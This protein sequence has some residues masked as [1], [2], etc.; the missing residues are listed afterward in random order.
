[1]LVVFG[2]VLVFAIGIVVRVYWIPTHT[3]SHPE[4]YVPGI[5]MP[6]G[7]SQP[8]ERLTVMKVLSGNY[9]SD[10]HPPGFFLVM[11]LWTKVFGTGIWSLRLQPVLLG[12]GTIA[13]LVWLGKLL[14]QT[15]A[16][17]LAAA[18]LAVNGF[19]VFWSQ[20]SRMF[21]QSCFLG[22][23]S[24]ILLLQL[25]RK[26]ETDRL[27]MAAYALVTLSGLATHIFYW[28]LF[29][30][31][32]LWAYWNALRTVDRMSAVCGLQL[33]ILLLGSP[34][35]AAAAYQSQNADLAYLSSNSWTMGREY[36]SF[37]FLL[38]LDGHGGTA[39]RLSYPLE[40]SPLQVTLF[41]IGR[42]AAFL[43]A[44]VCLIA[45]IPSR[46]QA[47][48]ICLGAPNELGYKTWLA[49]AI[50]AAAVI[51]V[52]VSFA[53]A[54]AHPPNNSLRITEAMVVLPLL[55]AAAGS[56]MNLR[57]TLLAAW[58]RKLRSG[59]WLGGSLALVYVQAFVPFALLSIFSLARPVLNARGLLVLTP[60]LLLCLAVGMVVLA[61]GK[62]L[63]HALLVFVLG[64]L[65]IT[66]LVSYQP[67]SES[68]VDFRMLSQK[69]IA[70]VQPSDIILIRR[71]WSD[72]PIL[73]YL[74]AERFHLEEI[75]QTSEV[76][77]RPSTNRVWVLNYYSEPLKRPVQPTLGDFT[78]ETVL[79]VYN[80]RAVLYSR[81]K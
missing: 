18:L 48:E 29:V 13:L 54:F 50:F 6:D 55:M 67:R 5:R 35:L 79:E 64:A 33:V 43:I 24:T 25:S 70:Q 76:L 37:S 15:A 75:G 3:M 40:R 69:L 46:K 47:E 22:V 41:L 28:P 77:S 60:F 42:I 19:H 74:P 61:R 81:R 27:L 32:M 72:T 66:S 30:S 59:W 78:V 51:L 44:V 9:T 17:W 52:F 36:V 16:G 68:P 10:I 34:L 39:S 23:L 80:G 49:A 71:L 38:P 65:H 62:W 21:S 4:M 14:G 58:C 63:L 45:G 11:L 8:H 57:W 7:L 2:L 56:L 31:Q 73:Y 12:L 20:I 53:L 1:M 26:K